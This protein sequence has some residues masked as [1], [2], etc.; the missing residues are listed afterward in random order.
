MHKFIAFLFLSLFTRVANAAPTAEELAFVP[1]MFQ[2]LLTKHSIL[3][4]DRQGDTPEGKHQLAKFL[5]L[6][7]LDCS[8]AREGIRD[9]AGYPA[10]NAPGYTAWNAAMDASS[11]TVWYAVSDSVS[12]A[13]G[14]TAWN[15]AMDASSPTVWD[16]VSDSIR[17]AAWSSACSAAGNVVWYAA[18]NAAM[19]SAWDFSRILPALK[20]S[21]L[22]DPTEIGKHVYK[23]EE[24]FV[25]GKILTD[26]DKKYEGFLTAAY[27]AALSKI[28]DDID[29]GH[30]LKT[31]AEATWEK[32]GLANN[33]FIM[34]LWVAMMGD[35]YWVT[36]IHT[37]LPKSARDNVL[38]IMLSFQRN[39]D[40]SQAQIPA[41]PNE[42]VL[43]ILRD[44]RVS[45]LLPSP[46]QE[47]MGKQPSP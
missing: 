29:H 32:P 35:L 42:I 39:N 15:A 2:Q 3:L 4:D 23:L 12:N 34:S 38:N 10:W 16:A 9:T 41:V 19:N 33:H 8:I 18:Y 5:A 11:P 28:S 37:S 14:Y 25:L 45:D 46:V 24:Y 40:P 13:D 1:R 47:T 7:T 30:V 6:Y 22:T 36:N 26:S 31:I 44:L 21:N 17:N 27:Q 20:L 43:A